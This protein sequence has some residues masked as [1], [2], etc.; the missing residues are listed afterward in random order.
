MLPTHFSLLQIRFGFSRRTQS[1]YNYDLKLIFRP[2]ED[3]V[4][5]TCCSRAVC[6]CCLRQIL[7][8]SPVFRRCEVVTWA[9]VFACVTNI[10]TGLLAWGLM[11]LLTGDLSAPG[12]AIF[13]LFVLVVCAYCLGWGLTYIPYLHL[14]PVF[15]MLVAG[16]IAR[17][18]GLYNIRDTISSQAMGS[19]RNFC[20][21]F[22][23][24]RSGIQL[25]TTPLRT[26]PISLIVLALLPCTIEMVVLTF[27]FKGFLGFPWDWAFL[28]G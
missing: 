7:I 14:P 26:H 12:G 3:D 19:I 4:D 25:N 13:N 15:G 20:L 21:T 16:I 9:T 6:C 1:R 10:I 8:K 23:M 28:G 24:V 18:S 2:E 5:V 11:Y 27:C 17:N 22:V